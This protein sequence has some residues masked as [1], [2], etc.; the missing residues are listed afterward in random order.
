MEEH[1]IGAVSVVSNIYHE[2]FCFARKKQI[3]NLPDI[4][5]ILNSLSQSEIDDSLLGLRLLASTISPSPHR[6][7]GRSR[8]SSRTR[9]P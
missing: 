2:R 7:T 9:I 3:Q 6:L 1:S 4:E 8:R 5:K